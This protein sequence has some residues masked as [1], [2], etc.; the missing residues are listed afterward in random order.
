M[1]KLV[2]SRGESR[3]KQDISAYKS[4]LIFVYSKGLSGANFNP[5]SPNSIFQIN[6][7]RLLTRPVNSYNNIPL[8][9]KQQLLMI[10]TGIGRASENENFEDKS[11]WIL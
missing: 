3:V 7:C 9:K 2:R 6:W 1:A 8:E 5:N 10:L 11:I 4:S